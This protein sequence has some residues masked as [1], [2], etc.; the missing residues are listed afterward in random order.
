MRSVRR[1][2]MRVF[3]ATALVGGALWLGH[4]PATA[5]GGG[6][7]E[8]PLSEAT[9]TEVEM[10][11]ACFTPATLHVQQGEVVRFTNLDPMIHNVAATGWTWG[12]VGDLAQGDTFTDRFDE[13]GVFPY[14]CSYHPGMSGTVIVEGGEPLALAPG[15]PEG[16]GTSPLLTG[17]GGIALGLGAGFAIASVRRRTIAAPT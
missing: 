11:E 13:A 15:V 4:A 10:L 3:A 7:C 12:H 2:T 17:V 5:G 8:D 14:A 6:R 16:P 9:G 1:G